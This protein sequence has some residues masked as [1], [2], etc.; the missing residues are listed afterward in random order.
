M[1]LDGEA[2][3]RRPL[4]DA[5]LIGRW[6]WRWLCVVDSQACFKVLMQLPKMQLALVL[7]SVACGLVGGLL[8]VCVLVFVFG[9]GFGAGWWTCAWR[10]W[11]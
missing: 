6:L 1:G 3:C 2:R 10:R 9:G 4:P 11:S 7:W 8:I 5:C